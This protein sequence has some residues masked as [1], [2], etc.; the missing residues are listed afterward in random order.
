MIHT[1]SQIQPTATRLVG[2]VYYLLA[3]CME[4]ISLSYRKNVFFSCLLVGSSSKLHYWFTNFKQTHEPP[5]RC[6]TTFFIYLKSLYCSLM[7]EYAFPSITQNCSEKKKSSIFNSP[8]DLTFPHV[9]SHH[10]FKY[11]FTPFPGYIFVKDKID[12]LIVDAHD[13]DDHDRITTH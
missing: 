10:P 8:F 3:F 5:Y 6:S 4:V 7:Y 9:P 11:L 2:K 12:E 13:D 1:T